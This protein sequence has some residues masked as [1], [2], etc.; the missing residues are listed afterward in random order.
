MDVQPAEDRVSAIDLFGGFQVIDKQG[1]DITHRFTSTL[2]ELFIFILLHS[3]KLEKG[4]S[5]TVLHEFL[6]PDKDEVSARNN[7]NVNLKKLRSLLECIGDVAIE[8]TNSYVRLTMADSVLCDYRTAYR[9]LG[10]RN[11]LARNHRAYSLNMF[12]AVACCLICKPY[13]STRSSR[14]YRIVL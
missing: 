10:S 14:K 11:D 2:K 6:W 8:N 5:T 12:A 13:G 3:V 7:R 4:V 1:T 9:I